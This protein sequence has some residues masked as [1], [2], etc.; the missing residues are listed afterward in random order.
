MDTRI[1]EDA[2]GTFLDPIE[3][4]LLTAGPEE[5]HAKSEDTF[6]NAKVTANR[7]SM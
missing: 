4:I 6:V 5:A 1:S 2:V 7:A 3:Y